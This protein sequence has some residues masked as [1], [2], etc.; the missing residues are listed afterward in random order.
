M[1]RSVYMRKKIV[2]AILVI[3][4]AAPIII[5][6][7]APGAVYRTTISIERCRSGLSAGSVMVGDHRIAYLEGGK[8][9]VVLLVHGFSGEKD[10][11]TRFARRLTASYHVVVPDLPGFGESTK[12]WK[13]RY[14]ILDQVDRLAGFI[15]T[16]K[17]GPVHLV[18]NSMGGNIAGALAARKPELVKSLA[19]YDSSGVTPPKKSVMQLAWDRGVNLLLVNSAE[20]YDRVM[21]LTFSKPIWLPGQVKRYFAEKAVVARPFNHKVEMDRRAEKF[22]LGPSLELIRVRTLILWGDDDRILDKSAVA[23]FERGI[24]DHVTV[25]MKKCGHVPMLERPDETAGH[26]LEFLKGV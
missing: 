7:A 1:E 5:Y 9:P 14:G 15:D 16:L 3:V 13:A 2:I 25:I 17:L 4:I 26:Y 19:L 10:H 22:E 12:S 24:R 23:L 8:G 20:D 21:K 6:F 11:W 18:G